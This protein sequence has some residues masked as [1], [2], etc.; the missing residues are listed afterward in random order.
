MRGKIFL[1]L[2]VFVLA[3]AGVQAQEESDYTVP[4]DDVDL[5]LVIGRVGEREI[6][7]GDFAARVRYE[8]LRYYRAFNNLIELAGVEALNVSDPNNVYAQ[9]VQTLIYRLVANEII[10]GELYDTMLL[11]ALYHDEAVQRGLT[12]DECEINRYWAELIN[13]R[14]E[15][16]DCVVPEGFE[17]AKT[18]FLTEVETFSGMAADDVELVVI[19]RAEYD[20]IRTALAAEAPVEPVPAVRTRHIRVTDLE[21]ATEVY[22]RLVAGE[23]FNTLLEAYTIDTGVTGNKGNLGTFGRGQMVPEFE[24]AVFAAEVGDII[25]PIETE[26]G[27]HIIEILPEITASHIL[28]STEEEANL[29]L[30]LLNEGQDF[31]TLAQQ[32]SIDSGSGSAGGALGTFGRGIMVPAFEDAAFA[33]EVGEV[34]GPVQTDFGYHLILVTSKNDDPEAVSARHIL[35]ATAEDAQT[36]LD[37]VEAGE[38][39]G[40]VA[41]DMSIDGTASG[42]GGDTLSVV[43]GGQSSGLYVFEE[44]LPQL[45]L[46]AFRAEVGDIIPPIETEYG[47]F[48]MIV[49]EKGEREPVEQEI[50]L[51][52][53]QYITTWQN[54]QFASDRIEETILWREYIP[55]DPMP[56]DFDPQLQ[57][58]EDEMVVAKA[59]LDAY[60]EDTNIL[61]TLRTLQVEPQTEDGQ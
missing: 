58:I 33:A 34:V 17:E 39:F 18:N 41:V 8:R 12:V 1:M 15:F 52:Q 32:F 14:D 22:D 21:T 5:S 59:E 36:A 37:R 55:T 24:D 50:Q 6:T 42:N 40:D 13:M 27:F 35:V 46:E 23:D 49:D 4:P 28:F 2:M 3:L 54:D 31:A 43:T 19:S 56:T 9:D 20:L 26:Y 25:G 38:D 51:E 48:V 7:L 47:Y 45:E 10:G 11:E 44:T 60:L 57:P 29:A 61:N 16:V 53:T 30:Q